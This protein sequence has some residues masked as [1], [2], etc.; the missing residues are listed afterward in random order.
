MDI[1]PVAPIPR[2]CGERR[3]GLLY[4]TPAFDLET[5]F[6]VYDSATRAFGR[7]DAKRK[8]SPIFV[9]RGGDSD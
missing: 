4:F 7:V 8:G 3:D 6:C 1:D 2:G 9:G 5:L